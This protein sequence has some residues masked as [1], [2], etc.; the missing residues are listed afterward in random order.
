MIEAGIARPETPST[1]RPTSEETD[2]TNPTTPSST[3]NQSIPVKGDT[4][5]VGPKPSHRSTMPAIP[6]MPAVRKSIPRD[7]PKLFAEKTPEGSQLEQHELPVVNIEDEEKKSAIAVT[8]DIVTEENGIAPPIPKAWTT[9]K[10]WTGLFTP[11]ATTSAPQSDSGSAIGPSL[12][13]TNAESVAETL[14]AFSAI[15]VDSRAVFLEPRGLVNTGNMCYMNS[16]SSLPLSGFRPSLSLG[17]VLQ[18]LVFCAPFYTFLDQV[19]KR[20]TH[21]FKSDTPL[22]D[23][24]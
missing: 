20:V 16:V 4:T 2:S 12:S 13:K 21:S 19:G 6:V 10:L 22:I 9:P 14:R 15:S 17:K 1:N 8:D 23:A 11:T 3:Q 7:I 18:V 5:P 24:M